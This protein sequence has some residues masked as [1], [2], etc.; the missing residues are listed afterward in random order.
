MKTPK[1]LAAFL[2]TLAFL[3]AF[4]VALRLGEG[5][6]EPAARVEHP[7]PIVFLFGSSRTEFGLRPRVIERT[8]E[9]EG[10][11]SPWVADVTHRALTMI[12]MLRLW[13]EQLRPLVEESGVRGWIGIEVRGSGL[14]DSYR[15]FDEQDYLER[16]GW[17]PEEGRF[18]EERSLARLFAADFDAGA[19]ELLRS[20]ALARRRR[21]LR[22]LLDPSR[23]L[24]ER[25]PGAE[26]SE[27]S[28]GP[29]G[30]RP[31][32]S[33]ERYLR[34]RGV[35]WA[36]GE[37]GWSIF[38]RARRPDLNA[39][40][41]RR[42]FRRHHLRDFRLGGV[43][44]ACLRTIIREAREAGLRP[45]L[46]VMPITAIHRSFF[47]PGDYER[48]LALVRRVAE[49]EG[50]EFFDLDTGHGLPDSAFLDT[51]HLLS[52]AADDFSRRFALRVLLP[53]LRSEP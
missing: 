45:F 30:E 10:I 13:R 19:R 53:L 20:L 11:A 1:P 2:W 17:S 44:T 51:G 34:S 48:F 21:E 49:V 8:L 38:R 31:E 3:G 23:W 15:V 9:R 26:R 6:A 12:G 43:Q 39:P 46:Y 4:E 24:P 22:G 14:N 47:E 18:L 52:T 25:G 33:W 16:L 35:P 28:S 36:F 42:R 40:V 50:I 32:S 29:G 37:K 5:R 7:G 27:S 41:E